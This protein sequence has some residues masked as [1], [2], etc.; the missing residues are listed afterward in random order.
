MWKGTY[1]AKILAC[2]SKPI[3]VIKKKM[4][5]STLSFTQGINVA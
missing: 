2:T 4:L 3:T 1:L 5:W